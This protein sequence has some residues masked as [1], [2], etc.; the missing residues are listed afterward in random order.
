MLDLMKSR[1]MLPR[2]RILYRSADA[3]P[4]LLILHE[5]T[6]RLYLAPDGWTGDALV[7]G[8][9]DDD[10]ALRAYRLANVR[11][12]QGCERGPWQWGFDSF[13]RRPLPFPPSEWSAF[14][15]RWAPPSTTLY[16]DADADRVVNEVCC[17]APR[18]EPSIRWEPSGVGRLEREWNAHPKGS[19]VRRLQESHG[20]GQFVV[21][22]E[23][24]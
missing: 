3:T 10:Q 14:D 5:P 9:L 11:V 1:C 18:D 21:I 22:D 17:G 7:A 15:P 12:P 4:F 13:E 16:S 8:P 23:P 2:G 6:Q 20:S 24:A 19:P